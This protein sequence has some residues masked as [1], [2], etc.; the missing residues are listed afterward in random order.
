MIRQSKELA[1]A[2]ETTQDKGV[3][4]SLNAS[5]RRREMA[6]SLIESAPHERAHAKRWGARSDASKIGRQGRIPHFLLSAKP[7]QQPPPTSEE[8]G[9]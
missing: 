1:S 3:E 4:A 6:L 2:E 5:L 9:A 7:L 8:L